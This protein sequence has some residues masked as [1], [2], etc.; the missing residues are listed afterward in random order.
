VVLTVTLASAP[1]TPTNL[2][3][4][5]ASATSVTLTWTQGSGTVTDNKV[6]YG[7]DGTTFGTTVDQGSAVTTAT[8]TGLTTKQLYF[9]EVDAENGSGASAYTAPVTWVCGSAWT[10]QVSQSSDD[11]Y[12]SSGTVTLTDATIS[13]T[14]G[15]YA[16]WRWQNVLLAGGVDVTQ[17]TLYLYF[18]SVSSPANTFSVDCQ[19]STSAAT[20][21]TA[22]N[23]I[24]GRSLTGVTGGAA[25]G[26]AGTG[27]N[28][29]PDL[30]GA[31]QAVVNQGGWASG[32]PI[33]VQ[34]VGN[35]GLTG[36]TIEMFDGNSVQAAI[37]AVFTVTAAQ[38]EA[39]IYTTESSCESAAS[40]IAL[41]NE[42]G[43][44]AS[45]SDH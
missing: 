22:S 12:E 17:A 25:V 24:S 30:Q 23:N 21:T 9:F 33:V 28:N 13:P 37:L 44:V 5:Y 29:F 7:T 2:V 14:S 15:K 38:W 3:A 35:T 16:G 41:N 34:F 42:W 6:K 32:D 1:G 45:G 8:I 11:A 18:S 19:A 10:G 27:W 26:G 31:V 4:S 40:N 43:V 20:F 39:A 36:I